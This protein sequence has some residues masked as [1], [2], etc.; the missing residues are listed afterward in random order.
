MELLRDYWWGI[1]LVFAL[2]GCFVTINQ[3]LIGVVT[4]FSRYHAYHAAGT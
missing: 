2:L 1:V 3:G 4:M